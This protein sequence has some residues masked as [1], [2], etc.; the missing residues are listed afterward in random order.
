[1]QTLALAIVAV[2]LQPDDE[3][4][5]SSCKQSS[6]HTAGFLAIYLVAVN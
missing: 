3:L 1:M 5:A 2:A 6:H 4:T